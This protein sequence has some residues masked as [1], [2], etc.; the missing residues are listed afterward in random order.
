[1][2]IVL[3]EDLASKSLRYLC[4]MPVRP[5]QSNCYLK[6]SLFVTCK[7]FSLPADQAS[8]VPKFHRANRDLLKVFDTI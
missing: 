2:L 6:V 1:M 3:L 5:I 7:F 4:F 8:T